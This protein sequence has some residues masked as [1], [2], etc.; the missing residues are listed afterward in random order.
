MQYTVS[1]LENDHPVRD[2]LLNLLPAEI[3]ERVDTVSE[4]EDA[5]GVQVDSV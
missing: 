3:P 1:G 5:L 4:T 2:M